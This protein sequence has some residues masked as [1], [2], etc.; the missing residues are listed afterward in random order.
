MP[1]SSR[2][3]TSSTVSAAAHT[4][5]RAYTPCGVA[6][7]TTGTWIGNLGYQRLD[8]PRHRADQRRRPLLHPPLAAIV[9]S[10]V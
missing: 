1:G 2:G 10:G 5:S 7:A 3:R 9:H 6:I 8:R 4:V